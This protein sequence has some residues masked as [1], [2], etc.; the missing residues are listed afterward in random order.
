MTSGRTAVAVL[1]LASTLGLVACTP[2]PAQTPPPVPTPSQT[3]TETAQERQ[4]RLDYA[5]AEKSYR[6]FRAEYERVLRAGGASKPTELMTA[7]AGGQYLATFAGVTRGFKQL[8]SRHV[9]QE[10][11]AYVRRGG[12]STNSLILNVCEDSRG[13]VTKRS[14]GRNERGGLLQASIEVRRTARSWKMW[15]GRGK[16]VTSCD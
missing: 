9:G 11:I 3:P 8:G 1:A 13:V 5:A 2:T 14:K 4:E 15:S 6:T 12:Y 7:T 10:K 16:Q